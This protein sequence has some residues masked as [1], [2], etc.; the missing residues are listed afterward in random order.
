MRSPIRSPLQF[1][2][3]SIRSLLN[4][5]SPRFALSSI[6]FLLNS[7]SPQFA[8][9]SSVRPFVLLSSVRPPLLSSS[10]SHLS[11]LRPPLTS[12]HFVLL[13]LALS[14]T[15]NTYS[16]HTR[17]LLDLR[18]LAHHYGHTPNGLADIAHSVLGVKLNKNTKIRCSKWGERELSDAQIEYAALDAWIAHRV[19]FCSNWGCFWGG[20]F[21]FFDWEKEIK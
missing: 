9:L 5:L 6:R 17:G 13:S 19:S 8:L 11:S 1:A 18:P 3:S 2:L 15:K 7:L 21:F 14:L 12:P 20:F 16:I 10:S 4:S